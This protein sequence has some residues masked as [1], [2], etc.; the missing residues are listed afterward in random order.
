MPSRHLLLLVPSLG[1]YLSLSEMQQ[2]SSETLRVCPEHLKVFPYLARFLVTAKGEQQGGEGNLIPQRQTELSLHTLAQ[3]F[4]A[5]DDSGQ[6]T[7]LPAL[8]FS[9][10]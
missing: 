3:H 9:L 2:W 4:P 5:G 7:R 10:L 6:V 8:Q 1:G